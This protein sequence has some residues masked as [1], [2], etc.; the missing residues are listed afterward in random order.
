[1][2]EC[3]ATRR[4]SKL[5]RAPHQRG[6]FAHRYEP[7]PASAGVGGDALA[8]IFDVE[9][10][11][12]PVP[13]KAHPCLVHAAHASR[14]CSAPPAG[15]GRHEWPSC[16]R[17]AGARRRVRSA[18][19]DR[20]A[21]PL[22]SCTSR[23]C[24]R[25]P[26]PRGST[27]AATATGRARC[28]APPVRP[29]RSRAGRFAAATPSG[30]WRPARPSIDPMAVRIWPNSSCSS[31]EISRSVD[32]RVSISFW[33]RSRRWSESVASCWNRRWFDRI[34]KALV[35]AI[36]ASVAEE[37]PAQLAL[38][39]R[40][41]RL[42]LLAPSALRSRCSAPGSAQLSCSAPPVAAAARDGSVPARRPRARLLQDQ[43]SARM[44]PRTGP[45]HSQGIA[46]VRA[47]GARPPRPPAAEAL[48]RD[49]RGCD[50]TA[51]TRR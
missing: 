49:R 29:R 9:F 19:R 4:P 51:R 47:C 40:V 8:V 33:V 28:R 14:R 25:A 12:T 45:R 22:S 37:E 21:S 32:S 38:H 30:A 5:E 18:P 42:H 43:R 1:M 27:D 31:R 23:P 24:C 48:R 26:V 50:R 36:A 10:E 16:R 2:D 7:Q 34:R 6:A 13:A 20:A 44:R 15:C 35:A 39:G 46:T 17:A 41:D 3:T 11:Q